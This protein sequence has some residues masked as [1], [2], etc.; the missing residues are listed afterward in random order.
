MLLP[1]SVLAAMKVPDKGK[2]PKNPGRLLHLV[3]KWLKSAGNMA[4]RCWIAASKDRV[5]WPEGCDI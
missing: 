3:K 1:S 4:E 5:D 2:N